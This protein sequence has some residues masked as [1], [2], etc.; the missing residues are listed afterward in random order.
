M[1]FNFHMVRVL[2][3]IVWSSSNR[4]SC[5]L[6]PGR[7]FRSRPL[8]VQLCAL[9]QRS[10]AF[11]LGGFWSYVWNRSRR[12]QRC[13][14]AAKLAQ[15][16]TRDRLLDTQIRAALQLPPDSLQIVSSE[17][18]QLNDL[19]LIGDWLPLFR[20]SAPYVAMF[21]QSIMV[22]HIQGQLLDQICSRELE[23][24][25]EDI[26]LCALLGVQPVL[27]IS[28]EHRVLGRLHTEGRE[29]L[30]LDSGELVVDEHVLRLVKQEAGVVCAEIECIFS[31]LGR[32]G[33]S[34]FSVYSSS[35]LFTAVP[36]KNRAAVGAGL[37]GR[38]QT[39]EIAQIQRRLN[40]A[41]IV[42]LTPLGMKAGGGGV[43]YVSS[44]ELAK[45]VAR[46]LQAAKL[47]FFTKGQRIV[48]TRRNT[49]VR[50]MQ[51]TDAKAF[52]NHAREHTELYQTSGSAEVLC[53]LELIIQA[54]EHGTRRG[55]LIDPTEGA[56]LQELY[57]TDGSG[58]LI[59]QDLYEGIRLANSSDVSGIL[60]LI[61]PLVQRGLLRRRSGYE[62]ECACN[63]G[64]LFVWTR[65]ETTIGCASLQSFDDAPE[66]A[67]LGCFVVAPHCRGKGHGAVLLSYMERI[68]LLQGFQMLF[69]L[70]TQTM[71]WFIERGFKAGSLADLPPGK[72]LSYDMGRS[73]RIYV[74]HLDSFPS[75][76]LERLTF[77]EVDRL[78]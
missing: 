9:R 76:V 4:H 40:D 15:W 61:E 59:S 74:K 52:V 62:V 37:R 26:T 47:V 71:Q 18:A 57:T 63:N 20:G 51:L 8:R 19:N 29:A 50:A 77:V 13:S 69:L 25:M 28:L 46:Q 32:N 53:Y 14:R 36:Q 16:A 78:D 41:D 66:K 49:L 34:A 33:Q 10:L 38:V 35:Q 68:A 22:F 12:C 1:N 3:E 44:E 21:R 43:Q 56:L 75:E 23:G 72:R 11:V 42:C 65:D 70:T 54:L 30:R 5:Q 67:E 6:I 60:E 27:V 7:F 31:R 55:H 58:T 48:D 39:V 24:L 17:T 64:E 45:E 73:S 2:P